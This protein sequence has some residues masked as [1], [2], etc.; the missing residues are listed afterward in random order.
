MVREKRKVTVKVV[1]R[2]SLAFLDLTEL[3]DPRYHHWG[4][5]LKNVHYDLH[6]SPVSCSERALV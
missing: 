3:N 2:P 5:Y 1:W 6:Y 4:K